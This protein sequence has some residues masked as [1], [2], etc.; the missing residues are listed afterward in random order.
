MRAAKEP[1]VRRRDAAQATLDRFKDRPLKLGRDD[2]VRMIAFHLRKLGYSV[3]LPPSGAYGTIRGALKELKA[4]GFDNLGAAIDA[5]GLERIAPASAIVG[6]ILMLP[7]A[8]GLGALH[9]ALGNGRTVAYHEDLIGAGVLQPLEFIA[10][11]RVATRSP[12]SSR[13]TAKSLKPAER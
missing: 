3:K 11:W 8:D 5:L 2:C 12:Q 9:I 1:L 7:S 13:D 6:D 4:R 10:A